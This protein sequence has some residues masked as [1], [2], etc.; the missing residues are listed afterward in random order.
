MF[1]ATKKNDNEK[2]NIYLYLYR[3]STTFMMLF[4]GQSYTV[5]KDGELPI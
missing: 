3:L 2:S 1:L 4:D 5:F